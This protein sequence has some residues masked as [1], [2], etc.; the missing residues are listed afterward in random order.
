MNIKHGSCKYPKTVIQSENKQTNAK[1]A[2][3]PAPKSRHRHPAY[4]TKRGPPSRQLSLEQIGQIN[5]QREIP[6]KTQGTRSEATS[7][8]REEINRE[9]EPRP[10][11]IT[12]LSRPRAITTS[13]TNHQGGNIMA[14]RLDSKL[15]TSGSATNGARPMTIN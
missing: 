8:A 15:R 3:N 6:T 10:R 13:S 11:A 4:Q 9:E 14:V 1:N 7:Q 2:Y 12:T 5:R